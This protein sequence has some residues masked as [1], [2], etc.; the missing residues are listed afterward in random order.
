MPYDI[1]GRQGLDQ[2]SRL[3]A[4]CCY[5]ILAWFAGL[6]QAAGHQNS[7]PEQ[8]PVTSIKSHCCPLY[9][10]PCCLS[11]QRWQVGTECSTQALGLNTDKACRLPFIA[12]RSKKPYT[13]F[14]ILCMLHSSCRS[15]CARPKALLQTHLNTRQFVRGP[16]CKGPTAVATQVCVSALYRRSLWA[17]S[18]TSSSVSALLWAK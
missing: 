3:T 4:C 18:A 2:A 15:H 9:S 12:T 8:G 7:H 17:S 1:Y 14:L 16:P 11:S 6:H 10:C 5:F 13:A